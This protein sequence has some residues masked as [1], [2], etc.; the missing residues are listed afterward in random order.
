MPGHTTLFSRAAL[1]QV[2][3]DPER[4]SVPRMVWEVVRCWGVKG[5]R[6]G[7]YFK[8][9]LYRKHVR[10]PE[11]FLSQRECEVLWAQFRGSRLGA[12]L[13]DK[14]LLQQHFQGVPG[15]RLPR[16]LGH[17]DGATFRDASGTEYPLTSAANLE[18]VLGRLL[19]EAEAGVF[20][21][22]SQGM[23]GRGAFRI[24]SSSE[25]GKLWEAV[26]HAPY[27]FQEAVR[28]HEGLAGIVPDTLNT[29]RITTLR[30]AGG[31]PVVASAWLKIGRRGAVA[32]NGAGM[33]IV[34]VDLKTGR[35]APRALARFSE[36][37]ETHLHHPDTGRMIGGQL[38]PML[39]EATA[40][41]VAAA[42]EVE[43]AVV[44][45]DVGIAVDG[46]VLLEGNRG[47]N[48]VSDEIAHGVG[49]LDHPV[50]GPYFRTALIEAA[51]EPS[52]V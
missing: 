40:M 52:S 27:I 2:L 34:A 51:T 43:S 45:W 6:P 30:E 4:K 17:A 39:A 12:V 3:R 29:L 41:A 36:G 48:F 10:R 26:R 15:V 18:R 47:T 5:E 31:D 24:S 42:H 35:L 46:P 28:Q 49:Y 8:S 1:R 32:D 11:G 25:A 7:H 37:G 33:L 21:K 16:Y 38:V 50:L 20:A 9:M 19:E 44:G 23:R 13:T 22:P 14:V